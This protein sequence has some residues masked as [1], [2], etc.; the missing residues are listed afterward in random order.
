[1]YKRTIWQDHVEGVQDGT[2]MNAA[3]FNN[4]EAG[5]MEAS[6]LA[7]MNSAHQRYAMA[8]G[9]YFGSYTGNGS[10]SSEQ[11]IDLGVVADAVIIFNQNISEELNADETSTGFELKGGI[12]TASSPISK[13]SIVLANLSGRN[14][15][16]KGWSF[17]KLNGERYTV[18]FNKSGEVYNYIAIGGGGII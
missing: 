7:A 5:T 2:D 14:L 18:S 8:S 13:N 9:V 15:T 12:V 10:G 4:I 16:V 1:M 6:A 3:N 17:T 11:T